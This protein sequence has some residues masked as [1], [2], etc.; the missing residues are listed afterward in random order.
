MNLEKYS[1]VKASGNMIYN[2]ISGKIVLTL[3]EVPEIIFTGLK[4][5][6][7]QPREFERNLKEPEFSGDQLDISI[8]I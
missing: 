7:G 6:L 5:L 8:P 4:D 1:V 2:N 3:K